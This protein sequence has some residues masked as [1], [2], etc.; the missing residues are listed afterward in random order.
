MPGEPPVL[1]TRWHD[2]FETYITV[3]NVEELG[4]ARKR[5]MLIHCLSIEGQRIL[6]SLGEAATYT[7]CVRILS[8]HFTAPQ[9]VIIQRILFHQCKQRECVCSP[10][11]RRLEGFSERMQIQRTTRLNV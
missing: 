2:A 10:M 11:H 6:K 4:E 1:C 8:G 5:T 7:D 9:N 3:L